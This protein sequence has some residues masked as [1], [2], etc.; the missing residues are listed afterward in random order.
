M[1]RPSV[2]VDDK[3]LAYDIIAGHSKVVSWGPEG[4]RHLTAVKHSIHTGDAPPIRVLPRRLPLHW[5]EEV[6][7]KVESMIASDAMEPS[8]SPWFSRFVL[9][10][11]KDGSVRFCVD[12]CQLNRV[13]KNN[14][15]SSSV[16]GHCGSADRARPLH[17]P[18]PGERLLAYPGGGTGQ[19]KDRLS[20]PGRTLPAQD[21]AIRTHECIS[22]LP[23]S[24][25]YHPAW[26][27]LARDYLVYLDDLVVFAGTHENKLD[28]VLQ[29]PQTQCKELEESTRVLRYVFGT[30]EIVTDPEKITDTG[31]PE[32][33]LALNPGHGAREVGLRAVLA[34]PRKGSSATP[35]GAVHPW[36]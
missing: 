6:R 25:E 31:S 16:R 22:D 23:A 32:I 10:A 27:Q 18:S 4:L 34:G 20:N 13:T 11:K 1:I 36:K 29:R 8:T 30:G 17:P 19:R 3:Y 26:S 24:H 12:Y 15:H 9:V 2:P 28:E 35:P 33:R 14:L 5:T 21:N 7:R